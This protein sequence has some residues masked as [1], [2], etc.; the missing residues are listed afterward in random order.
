[1]KLIS[2]SVNDGIVR[3]GALLEDGNLVLDLY[4]V[5]NDTRAVIAA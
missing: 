3:P 5:Y 2:F 4:S 1:M